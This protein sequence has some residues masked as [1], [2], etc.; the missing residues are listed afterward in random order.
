MAEC[1]DFEYDDVNIDD[2]DHPSE[3]L[4][5]IGLTLMKEPVLLMSDGHSYDKIYIDQWL[6]TSNVSP[7]T[8]M[9]LTTKQYVVN[10]SLKNQID[11]YIRK[12]S[13]CKNNNIEDNLNK[14]EKKLFI[15]A[16]SKV[17]KNSFLIKIQLCGSVNVGKTSIC[18]YFEFNKQKPTVPTIG[19][20]FS[21]IKALTKYENKNDIS[22]RLQ[23]ICGQFDRTGRLSQSCYRN[24][25][26]VIMVISID[27]QQ[28][29]IDLSNNWHKDIINYA[30][31]DIYCI[32]LLN[33]FDLYINDKTNIKYK[34]TIEK[35]QLFAKTNGYPI[36]NTSVIKGIYIHYSLNE[37]ID[38]ILN[39]N[40]LWNR[41][42][43]ENNSIYKKNSIDLD[44]SYYDYNH[45]NH[46]K[47]NTLCCL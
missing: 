21:F 46:K 27:D 42:K 23:D 40:Q 25:H 34:K 1:I 22:I 36:Y 44:K 28:S 20:E 5:P 38:R 17:V 14:K 19:A 6:Q 35:A 31:D 16:C 2:V 24:I 37:L 7:I 9:I 3:F 8:N 4:C 12:L 13:T 43:N 41:I 15:P 11:E 30:P 45:K 29:V 10:R 47:H 33:K 26:G 18:K 32:V 39:D